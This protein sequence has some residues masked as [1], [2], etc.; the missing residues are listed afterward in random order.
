MFS[1]IVFIRAAIKSVLSWF[2]VS[3]KFYTS[4]TTI[5]KYYS[6]SYGVLLNSLSIE[7]CFFQCCCWFLDENLNNPFDFFR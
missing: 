3:L 2:F 6:H 5:W 4:L 7:I 1:F